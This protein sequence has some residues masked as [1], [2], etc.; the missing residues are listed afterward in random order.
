MKRPTFKP[1]GAK[2]AFRDRFPSRFRQPKIG[3]MSLGAMVPNMVTIS[4]LCCG[5]TAIQMALLQ[6]WDLAIVSIL[7]A[8]FLDTMDGRLARLLNSASRFGAELDSFSDLLSFGAAPA[9]IIYLRILNQ[10]GEIGW[11]ICLF[12]TVC[13]TLRLARFNTRSIEGTNPTWGHNFFTGVPAPAGGYLAL[14]PLIVQQYHPIAV[15]EKPAVYAGFLII[16]GGLMVSR[17]PTFSLKK[18]IIPHRLVVP[19]MLVVFSTLVALYSQLWLTLTAIGLLYLGLIPFSVLA[20]KRLKKANEAWIAI[21]KDG[22]KNKV[23]G[24]TGFEPTTPIPPE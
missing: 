14:L 5:M 8:G 13:M 21:G 16:T 9:L 15:L 12:F 22:I 24:T 10:W 11:G 3:K 2:R 23:V 6:R 17:I 18:M 4:A 1:N 20:H 19:L 7:I